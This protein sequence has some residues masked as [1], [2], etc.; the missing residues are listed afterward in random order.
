MLTKNIVEGA[1]DAVDVDKLLQSCL[2]TD[3]VKTIST[4]VRNMDGSVAAELLLKMI[5]L[6]STRK[7]TSLPL[8]MHWMIVTHGGYLTTVT[9]VQEPLVKLREQLLLC[10][11]N[12]SYITTLRGRLDMTL[13]QAKL[14]RQ[15]FSELSNQDE[16]DDLDSEEDLSSNDEDSQEE[17]EIQVVD[18]SL[19]DANS[20]DEDEDDEDEAD[21]ELAADSVTDKS[22]TSNQESTEQGSPES[23]QN[24]DEDEE[25]NGASSSEDDL[26]DTLP[27]GQFF[28][29][30]TNSYVS[31]ES[32]RKKVAKAVN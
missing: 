11:K 30:Q 17:Y 26:D 32:P 2:E 6:L 12:V 10:L 15:S 23:Q 8:W 16:D 29:P 3:D 27:D 1:K 14:R 19:G 24:D 21:E 22:S 4:S 25:E 13:G 20:A 31:I 7:Y 9:E 18:E 5:P 28:K